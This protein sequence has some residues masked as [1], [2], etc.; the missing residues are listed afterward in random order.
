MFGLHLSPNAEKIKNLTY[1]I[2]F[3]TKEAAFLV[4]SR[5]KLRWKINILSRQLKKT[6]SSFFNCVLLSSYEKNT[7]AIPE[8]MTFLEFR[9][10]FIIILVQRKWA[11][12][13]WIFPPFFES[14]RNLAF[15]L[16]TR[17]LAQWNLIR[18]LL[19]CTTAVYV[20]IFFRPE[21]QIKARKGGGP[22]MPDWFAKSPRRR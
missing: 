7:G 8:K 3:R 2:F 20:F 9:Q 19:Q 10:V 11:Y 21:M 15:L 13:L 17:I 6:L 22:K 12:T 14:F 1:A 4:E 5:K 18:K 16:A